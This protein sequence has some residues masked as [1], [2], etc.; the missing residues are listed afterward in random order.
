[1]RDRYSWERDPRDGYVR[2]FGSTEKFDPKQLQSEH[3]RFVKNK[4]YREKHLH[5]AVCYVLIK[6]RVEY[7][8]EYCVDDKHRYHT[9]DQGRGFHHR[10]ADLYIPETDTAIEF[11]LKPSLKGLGQAT[12]YAQHHYESVL[13]TEQYSQYIANTI[14][15]IPGVHYGVVTPGITEE[16][17]KLAVESDSRCKFFFESNHGCLGNDEWFVKKPEPTARSDRS[18]SKFESDGGDSA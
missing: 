6:N 17:P 16:P 8:S 2:V 5:E 7:E 15:S 12:Y 18:L 13:L 4:N 10:K 9:P 14:R 3:E 11:K 1:M